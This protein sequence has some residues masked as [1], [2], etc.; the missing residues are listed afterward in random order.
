MRDTLASI[1]RELQGIA[2]EDLTRAEKNVLNMAVKALGWTY[3]VVDG[4]ITIEK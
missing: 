2:Y 3:T 4:D 1:V